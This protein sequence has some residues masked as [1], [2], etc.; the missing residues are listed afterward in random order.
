MTRGYATGSERRNSGEHGVRSN[1]PAAGSG[2]NPAMYQVA[3]SA[4]PYSVAMPPA[5]QLVPHGESP[6]GLP[7]V[8]GDTAFQSETL[9]SLASAVNY[10][11]WLTALAL[12]YL[13]DAPLELGSGLGD[14]AQTWL[15]AG[16]PHIAASEIDPARLA[17]LRSRFSA[18][19]RAE[20]LSF[21]VLSPKPADYSA[22]VA[23]NVLEHIPDDVGALRAALTL[24]R[25]GA[26]V[27]MF[28]PAFD[29]AMSRFDR[30]VG[31]VRRYTVGSMR[32]AM[33]EAGL[34]GIETRYVNMLGLPAWYLGMKL[35]RMSPGEGPLLRFWDKAV[36]PVAR[37]W[38]TK[39]RVPFGQ[40]V[41]AIGRVPE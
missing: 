22:L 18:E 6:E 38:E 32:A 20:V 21:D 25:P 34:T 12:P 8:L 23:F 1:A 39:H 7:E 2:T 3:L 14:Y 31:H 5:D 24:C 9:E 37:R 30:Q 28:V 27:V 10:N 16:I 36:I 15:D 26:A 33:T 29:W 40:S 17:Q 35:A 11:S 19:P 13:G 4:V 41:F